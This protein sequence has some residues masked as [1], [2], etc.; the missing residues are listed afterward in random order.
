MAK[1]AITIETLASTQIRRDLYTV[2]EAGVRSGQRPATDA[3]IKDK[4]VRLHALYLR[5]A[6][7]VSQLTP[8]EVPTG[9]AAKPPEEDIARGL[10]QPLTG[11]Q[12]DVASGAHGV[13]PRDLRSHV[14]EMVPI[15]QV[16][17]VVL[18]SSYVALQN[19]I[20]LFLEPS[21][22]TGSTAVSNSS[23]T[24]TTCSARPSFQSETLPAFE[25]EAEQR[26]VDRAPVP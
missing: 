12:D 26:S 15:E 7:H 2:A 23:S 13:E 5:R 11:K 20:D 8:V 4:L 6:R 10:H 25:L 21:H 18:Q 19:L 1:L 14:R 16:M 24:V 22:T 9:W 3:R 17:L